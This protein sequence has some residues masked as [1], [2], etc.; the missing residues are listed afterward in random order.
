M[1]CRTRLK[2]LGFIPNVSAI[3]FAVAFGAT[4]TNLRG[5]RVV[6]VAVVL[7][8]VLAE[9][10]LSAAPR[11]MV[12]PFFLFAAFF[13]AAFAS[14]ARLCIS[15]RFEAAACEWLFCLSVCRMIFTKLK[16][17]NNFLSLRG[18]LSKSTICFQHQL[19]ASRRLR[20][21]SVAGY[22][23][24]APRSLRDSLGTG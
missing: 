4:C 9:A 17:T 19:N 15:L 20:S 12:F 16:F 18:F 21:P 22:S 23:S 14:E 8:L 24:N 6:L 13:L 10:L 5:F 1:I 2:V 11:V 7:L 3:S